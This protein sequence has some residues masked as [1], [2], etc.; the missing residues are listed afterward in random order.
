[1]SSDAWVRRHWSSKWRPFHRWQSWYWLVVT[2]TLEPTLELLHTTKTGIDALGALLEPPTE[3]AGPFRQRLGN[4]IAFIIEV[5]LSP[6]YQGIAFASQPWYRALSVLLLA[7]AV[8]RLVLFPF[9]EVQ[10][11]MPE[12]MPELLTCREKDEWAIIQLRTTA[13]LRFENPLARLLDFLMFHGDSY[14][15]EHHLWPAMSFVHLRQ[16]SAIVKSACKEFGVPYHE[17]G[18]WEGYAKILHQVRIHAVSPLDDPLQ[19]EHCAQEQSEFS[20]ETAAPN[21]DAAGQEEAVVCLEPC[22]RKRNTEHLRG[23]T[24][25]KR[26]RRIR[27]DVIV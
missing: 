16:A 25:R 27:E 20:V 19:H 5:L 24:L 11:Y 18:Y 1:M 23:T 10:H 15:V 6:G 3:I 12:H 9:A 14:Q 22:S 13:N 17:V 4:A 2:S 21:T 7:R 8:S 26:R